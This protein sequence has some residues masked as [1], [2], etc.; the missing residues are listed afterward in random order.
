MH[1]Y[2]VLKK[3]TPKDCYTHNLSS[4]NL[5]S[6]LCFRIIIFKY[7]FEVEIIEHFMKIS[8]QSRT[9]HS[10]SQHEVR[11]RAMLVRVN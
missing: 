11:L 4:I 9:P 7:G 3:A 5:I 8:A 1:G 10:D 2:K 6:A